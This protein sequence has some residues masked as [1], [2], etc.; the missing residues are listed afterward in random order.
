M[1]C[2]SHSGSP[3]VVRRPFILMLNYIQP[4]FLCLSSVFLSFVFWDGRRNLCLSSC[5]WGDLRYASVP[6]S[7]TFVLFS[8]E[9]NNFQSV[10]SHIGFTCMPVSSVVSDSLQPRGLQPTRLFCPWNF[11]GKNTGVSCYFLLQGIFPT[12][13]SNSCLLPLLHCRQILYH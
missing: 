9:D 5:I 10:I 13:D 2:L 8:Q 1:K 4:I 11:P 3:W 12:Q 6:K 7:G